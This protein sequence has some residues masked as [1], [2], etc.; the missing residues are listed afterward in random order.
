[1]R[2]A[3]LLPLLLAACGTG[4]PPPGAT[5]AGEAQALNEAAAMLD[6]NSVEANAVGIDG[7]N[8][9]GAQ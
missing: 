4:D 3:V 9:D 7:D 6:A 1:M 5:S 8:E 2:A